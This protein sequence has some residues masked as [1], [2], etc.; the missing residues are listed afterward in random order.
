MKRVVVLIYD[1]PFFRGLAKPDFGPML[2]DLRF[3]FDRQ[4]VYWMKV[5]AGRG[6]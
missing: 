5:T 1:T 2:T 4:Q 3:R 6:S